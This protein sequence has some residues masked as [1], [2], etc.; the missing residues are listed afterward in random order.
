LVSP[1]SRD[2]AAV[3]S[4]PLLAM[5][6]ISKSF[7]RQRVL[8]DVDFDLHAGEVHVLA[9]ENGAGKTTLI[10]ILGGVHDPDRGRIRLGG[11]ERRFRS[12]RDAAA[13]GVAIIHQELSLVPSMSVADNLFLGREQ[14]PGG[15][16]RFA[17]QHRLACSILNRLG[18]EIEAQRPAGAFPISVQQLIEIGKAL[19]YEAQ[20]IVM[21]EPTSALNEPEVERLFATVADLKARGC[22][23]IYITHKLEEVYRIADRITVLRDGV[24]ID[25]TLAT[26]MPPADLIRNMVGRELNTHAKRKQIMPADRP[27]QLLVRNMTVAAEARGRRP[28]VREIS[29]RIRAG[30]IVGLAGLQ[31]SGNSDLLWGLF[32]AY[33]RRVT[34]SFEIRGERY[35][36]RSPRHAI[37]HGIALLTNDRK[38]SGLV[39]GMS[40][41]QNATLAS[42]DRVS[43]GGW[44]LSGR[45]D[46]LARDSTRALQLQAASLH[47]S[48]ATLSGGNQQKVALAK[49]LNTEPRILLLDEPTRGVDVG[50]KEE[51]Y[52][53]MDQWRQAGLAIVLITSEMPELLRMSDR[54][55]VLHRGRATAELSSADATQ[56]RILH[57]AMGGDS[58]DE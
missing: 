40:V 17:E 10:K 4:P 12:P 7:G 8:R 57:A 6:G 51:I 15:W 41:T 30:E 47:Q 29:F 27:V 11:R 2:T 38:R 23:I 1:E 16:M 3:P 55:L 20:V 28:P 44:V 50:A 46:R 25:T 34:G 36:P 13:A 37:R 19:A 58:G 33:G 52:Q 26:R 31:G 24:R 21:D 45:E 14:A 22:G 43:P 32:G 56:E 39:L 54:I 48:V 49:W 42:L 5:S 53:L 9:G 35:T 18:L